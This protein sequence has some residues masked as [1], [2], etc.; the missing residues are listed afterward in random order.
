VLFRTDRTGSGRFSPVTTCSADD[1]HWSCS[2]SA[3]PD[4]GTGVIRYA[5]EQAGD[6][7]NS[8]R[9]GSWNSKP[10]IR[11]EGWFTAPCI[12]TGIN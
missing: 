12:L 1:L 4:R 6:T 7:G 5:G 9:T 11:T 2:G 10:A 3:I 8:N